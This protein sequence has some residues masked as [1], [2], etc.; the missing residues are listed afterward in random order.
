MSKSPPIDPYNGNRLTAGL[1]PLR[2]REEVLV[3]LKELPKRP[4]TLAG[5][6]PHIRLHM[7]MSLR[8]LHLPSHEECCLHESIELMT[9]QNYSYLDPARAST[10]SIVGGEEPSKPKL[11]RA[12]AFGAAVEGHSGTGKTEAILRCLNSYPQQVIHHETFPQLEGPHK[13]VVWL[14]VDVP[15]SGRTADLAASLMLA[16]EAATHSGRFTASLAR[17]RRDGMRMLEEWRQVA[18]AHFLGVLHLDEVQNFFKLA[19]LKRRKKSGDADAS[20][21]P[22]LSIVEDQAL[23]W[24]LTLINTWQVPVL[25]SGTPDGIGAL[26][27]RLS[28]TERIVT[29]GYH[30]FHPFHSATD[31]AFRNTFL[32]VLGRY[33]YVEKKLPVDNA[34]AEIIIELTGGIQRLIIALWIAAHRIA[35]ERKTDDL[36]LTD[37]QLAAATYLSPVLPAVAALR[38]RDP[39]RMSQYEDLLPREGAFWT[40]F[41]SSISRD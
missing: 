22:L 18:S 34:L 35:F 32:V 38:S 36:R 41:W 29:S 25:L 2:S 16:W 8:N 14:S 5:V 19:T 9:R 27:R 26:T 7:L 39:K 23:K 24:I 37:F 31:P 6:A 10:W 13:Q 1:G 4:Q 15:A 3:H 11:P 21:A 17:E 30:P 12:P 20:D 28:N 40:Q 33:Q